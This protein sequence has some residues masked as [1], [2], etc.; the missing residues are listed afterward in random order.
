LAQEQE[1]AGK[2]PLPAVTEPG[3]SQAPDYNVW[4][5]EPN[6]TMGDAD[7]MSLHDVMGADMDYEG[8]EDFFKFHVANHGSTILIDTESDIN[9][10]DVDT[11]VWLYDAAGNEIGLD[12]DSSGTVDSLLFRVLEP[13][14][15]Y[16]KVKDY[17][18]NGGQPYD[19]YDLIVS[20][21]LLISADAKQLG[22]GYVA[23]IP[24]K[25]ED[26][27]AWSALND[28]QEKWVM[29]VDG[30]DVGFSK[31]VINLS[32]G[33]TGHA[34]ANL[35]VGFKT[36]V[37]VTDYAGNVQ[38]VKAWDWMHFNLDQAGS[39][40]EISG[41]EVNR[42]AW[43]GLT[44]GPEKVDAI[45]IEDFWATGSPRLDRYISTT[46]A[47]TFPVPGGLLKTAD[48]DVFRVR[49]LPG[50]TYNNSFFDG[51]LVPG[52]AAEEV[53]AMSYLETYNDLFLTI[54]GTGNIAGHPVSQ[55]DIF[56]IDL[57]G[58]TWGALVW[59]GPDHGWNY[60]I[61]AIDFPSGW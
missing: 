53:H 58:H 27:L 9:G 23:G 25:S 60:N 14:W 8:D 46:G 16:I 35:A 12:D 48:E 41:R 3:E 18:G 51:S 55:K 33:W 24:F 17:Y 36:N 52:L 29:L 22:T 11:K 44:K 38:I 28:G 21:P 39:D 50:Q 30:S 10:W 2:A 40:S 13:G 54:L 45:S 47:A 57:P 43:Y 20:S 4:E 31:N 6:N 37:T 61:D 15:W 1:P 42:G 59:H 49:E 7:V 5:S 19:T 56:R 26:I 34:S 32:R